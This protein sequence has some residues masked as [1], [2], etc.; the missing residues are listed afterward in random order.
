MDKCN[1]GIADKAAKELIDADKTARELLDRTDVNELAKCVGFLRDNPD[2][3]LFFE[4]LDTVITEGQ[5]VVRSGRTLEYYRA[6]RD[7]CR[8]YLM[9]YKDD[10]QAMARVLGWAVRLMR[11][12]AV[13]DQPALATVP[14][15]GSKALPRQTGRVKLFKEDRGFGFIQ[16]DGGGPEVYVNQ[17]D[18]AAGSLRPGQRVSYIVASGAKGPQARDV[19]PE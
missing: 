11:Y 12:Y 14:R 4:Y 1:S 18:V 9:L 5:A 16:P 17:R 15:H 19:Q 2:G 6:I 3:P 7:A 10:S 13:A 8:Q